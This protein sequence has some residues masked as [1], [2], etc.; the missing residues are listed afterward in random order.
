MTYI[1]HARNAEELKLEFVSDIRRR[2]ASLDMQAK[3]AQ[4]ETHKAKLGL[5]LSE[6]TEML[7]YWQELTIVRP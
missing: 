1:S 7:N 2:L 5:A 3:H 4:T 6:F